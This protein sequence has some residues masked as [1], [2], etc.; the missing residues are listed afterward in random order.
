MNVIGLYGAIGWNV[1]IS[2]NPKLRQQAEE[3][4][5]HGASVTLFSD[6]N[7]IVSISEERLSGIK[8]DGNFPRKSIEYCLSASNL[9]KEDIDVVVVPSMANQNFYKNY[10]NK[11][12]EKKSQKIFSKSKSRDCIAPYVS[13]I[14]F[15]ILLRS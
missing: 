6:G 11:T 2:D 1:L 3:S 7:H 5:T 10:I 4:W 13:C 15:C 9:S 14:L 8:Y 12:V